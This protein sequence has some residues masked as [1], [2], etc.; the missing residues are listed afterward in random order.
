MF[1]EFREFAMRG[2]VID[3]AVGVIIGAAFGKITTSLV[4]DIL[5][6]PL[7]LVMGKMDFSN[8]ALVLREG[9]GPELVKINYG[10]FINQ[11]VN[12]IIT[13]F[14]MF[15]VIRAINRLN[16]KKVAPPA[17]PTTKACPDCL[18]NV[19]LAAK[20]CAFCTSTLA[21]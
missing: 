1:K 18:S 14:A 5:M 12:F 20:R 11:V 3:L 2:N 16:R 8:L 13:A 15:L 7:G 19:P 9:V 6:P 21:A 4:N 10:L 17:A